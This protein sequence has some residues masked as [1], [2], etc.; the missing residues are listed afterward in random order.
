MGSLLSFSEYALE[1][2]V[3]L[4]LPS[5]AEW[6][7]PSDKN[8]FMPRPW[9][10]APEGWVAG[11]ELPTTLGLTIDGRVKWTKERL[12]ECL[13]Q[14]FHVILVVSG[15]HPW[16]LACVRS[17]FRPQVEV[18]GKRVAWFDRLKEDS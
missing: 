3:R 17:R 10:S 4:F 15:S 5:S 1:A 16:R 8:P 14:R 12:A 18:D 11:K 13:G 6:T 9:V 2:N 7:H